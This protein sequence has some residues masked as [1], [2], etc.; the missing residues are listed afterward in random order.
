MKSSFSLLGFFLRS[1]K[2]TWNEIAKG[3]NIGRRPEK[4]MFRQF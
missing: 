2:I 4:L 3:L 1:F